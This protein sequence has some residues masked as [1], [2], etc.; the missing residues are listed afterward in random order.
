MWMLGLGSLAAA[1][2]PPAMRP[3]GYLIAMAPISDPW[4]TPRLARLADRHDAVRAREFG[5]EAE[6][7]DHRR[8]DRLY[9]RMVVIGE[10]RLDRRPGTTAEAAELHVRVG[11]LLVHLGREDEAVAQWTEALD[12]APDGV[13]AAEAV[14]GLAQVAF[15]A[16][17]DAEAARW[18]D[19]LRD[20]PS[21]GG[22]AAYLTAWTAYRSGNVSTAIDGAFGAADRQTSPIGDAMRRDAVRFAASADDGTVAATI[23]RA[24]AADAACVDESVALVEQL[25]ATAVR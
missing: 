19:R 7:T 24:C 18:L 25:R 4:A 12:E 22:Y 11:Y 6:P 9:A 21:F 10:R 16:G 8:S 2:D 3:S 5:E 13:L 17:D 23:D 1:A 20:D 15:D 14:L